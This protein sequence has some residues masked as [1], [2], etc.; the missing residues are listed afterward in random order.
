MNSKIIKDTPHW[1]HYSN[2]MRLNI[3]Y[4]SYKTVHF[5][6]VCH[7]RLWKKFIDTKL[8][9]P[10]RLLEKLVTF[11][12]NWQSRIKQEAYGRL[13][14]KNP[15]AL[16]LPTGSDLLHFILQAIKEV[17]IISFTHGYIHI[18]I[19]SLHLCLTLKGLYESTMLSSV[20]L[21]GV[22]FCLKIENL[23]GLW[24]CSEQRAIKNGMERTHNLVTNIY[25]ASR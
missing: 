24:M 21:W 22:F 13:R 17:Q 19:Y 3:V 1:S 12:G 20:L 7:P 18:C 10:V 6:Y 4:I 2:F 11:L 8:C 25:M 9:L 23:W 14:L 16:L 5:P 15:S